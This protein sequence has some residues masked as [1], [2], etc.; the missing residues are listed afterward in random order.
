MGKLALIVTVYVCGLLAMCVELITP[1]VVIGV[2]GFLAAMGSIIYAFVNGYTTAG[3]VLS[4]IMIIFVPVF[5]LLW[6]SVASRFLASHGREEGFRPSTTIREHL[7][8]LEG[9]AVSALRP[10][11]IAHLSGK[12]YDVVTRGEML[13]RG[14]KVKVIEVSGNRIVVKQG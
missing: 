1:G 2:V 14:T 10:S 6:K 12:R 13:D 3:F 9:E 11:G 5:F 7:V 8:G 4:I